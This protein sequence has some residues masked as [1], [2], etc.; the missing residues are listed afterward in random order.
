MIY[1]V[2]INQSF[3]NFL[4]KH[5]PIILKLFDIVKLFKE[6]IPNTYKYSTKYPSPRSNY[7]YT[8]KLFI[9]CILYVVLN[10][11]SWISFI[12]PIPG[13]QVHK[14]FKE[15]IKMNCF[16]KLFQQSIK[17]YLCTDSLEKTKIIS[18]DTTNIYNKNCKELKHKNPYLKNKRSAKISSFVDYN[19][20]PLTISISDSNESDCK[21]FDKEFNK[22]I[23]NNIIKE[24]FN[25]K[26]IIL[27]DKGYDT[28]TIREKIYKSKMKCIIPFNKRNTKN[29]SK[30][31]EL[32]ENEKKIYKKRIKVEHYFSIIKK[33][34]KI[35][36]VYE[37][38]LSSYLNIVLLVSSMILINRIS[39][40]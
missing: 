28:R 27:A 14:K 16:N 38:S 36:C 11:S 1:D 34:P 35:N 13:K 33:Y 4:N 21:L 23:N 32:N 39:K 8:D 15:F 40:R 37:K 26:C 19:G 22:L 3:S 30:I 2:L 31:K 20:S 6:N 17:E 24:K 7:K 5:E 12:G 18:T 29:K 25:K 9:G 10:N